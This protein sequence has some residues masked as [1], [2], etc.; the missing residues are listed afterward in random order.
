M[1]Q[2][3]GDRKKNGTKAP[4]KSKTNKTNKSANGSKTG[5]KSGNSKTTT[6]RN[7]THIKDEPGKN[8]RAQKK[9]SA[10]TK[11]NWKPTP[12]DYRKNVSNLTMNLF[13]MPHQFPPA[14]DPRVSNISEIVGKRFSENFLLETPFITIIP[15]RPTYMPNIKKNVNK[16]SLTLGLIEAQENNFKTLTTMLKEMKGDDVK[17]YDFKAAYSEY[18]TYVNVLCRAGAAFLELAETVNVGGME[19]SFQKYDWR[20]YKWNTLANKSTITRTLTALSQLGQ[21]VADKAFR[22][23]KAGK[24]TTASKKGINTTKS[25]QFQLESWDDG[26]KTEATVQEL[27][28]NY[29]YVQFYIDPESG[30]SESISNEVGQPGIKSAIEGGSNQMKDFQFMANAAG[31]NFIS[32][33]LNDA[34]KALSDIQANV[35]RII[36]ANDAN[37]GIMKSIGNVLNLG[38]E[39][40]AGHNILMPNIYQSSSYSKSFSVNIHLKTPYANKLAWYLNVFVPWMHC[41]ALCV[42]PQETANSFSAPFLVKAYID[43]IYSCNLG[44]VTSMSVNKT[45]GSY[46]IDGLPSEI[47]ISLTIEDLYSDLMLSPSTDPL[48]FLSNSS[49]IEFL[50]TSCGM[51]IIA[52]N[53]LSKWENTVNTVVNKFLDIPNQIKAG[54]NATIQNAVDAITGLAK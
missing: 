14:V 32:N 42:P 7:H 28:R 19:Y 31:E 38:T 20:A 39:V 8:K 33:A 35:A 17:L 10:D 22:K 25:T 47:D 24:Y 45:S 9:K 52:P 36:G 3:K 18:M 21:R 51:S 50:C 11:A 49:L 40:I 6:S 27:L 13:G 37:S 5:S 16:H 15:G 46:S 1:G 44:L 23:S 53:Q 41:L 12:K 48:K 30:P 43:G 26:K 29:N 54:A 34:P 4:K 2:T